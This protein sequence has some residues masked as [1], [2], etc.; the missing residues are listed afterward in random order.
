MWTLSENPLVLILVFIRVS[1]MFS[2]SIFYGD[3][4]IPALVKIGLCAMMSFLVAPSINQGIS[5][6][7]SNLILVIYLFK[8]FLIGSIIGLASMVITNS[9]SI[10]GALVDVQGGF[11]MSQVFD[12]ATRTQT[13]LIS[14]LFSMTALMLFVA[15]GLHVELLKI[16]LGTFNTIPLG[17]DINYIS[18]V[19]LFVKC[20]LIGAAIAVP[21]ISLIFIM[22]I[23]LGVAAKTMP[24]LSV[25]S[26]GFII[27]CFATIIFIYVYTAAFSNI[28]RYVSNVVFTFITNNLF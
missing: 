8:E 18:I 1:T 12:P 27:K 3:K 10:A 17:G 4:R 2:F 7:I 11:G 21:V 19:N 13:S 22:D 6:D 26:V 16:F 25:F 23:L 20:I 9:F 24:Q 15:Q 5:V 14:K 28:T